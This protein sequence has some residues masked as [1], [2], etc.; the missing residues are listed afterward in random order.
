MTNLSSRLAVCVAYPI[1]VISHDQSFISSE[2]LCCSPHLCC[3]SWPIF[4]LFWLSV[5]LPPS[6][7]LVMT[8]LSSLLAICVAHPISAVSHDQSFISSG[9]LCCSPYLCCQSW[10]SSLIGHIHGVVVWSFYTASNVVLPIS[11][12]NV[13]VGVVYVSVVSDL[14]MSYSVICNHMCWRDCWRV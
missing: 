3:Q 2:C 5:L 10:W 13:Y 9:C 11:T 1:S 7:S 14:W 8:N 12:V 6:L 4:H